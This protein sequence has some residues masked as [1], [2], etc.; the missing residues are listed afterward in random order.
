[1]TVASR[2]DHRIAMAFVCLGLA[3]KAPVTVDDAGPIAT[4]FPGF[5]E[6]MRGLGAEI[7]ESET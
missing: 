3:A 1:V 6:L 7:G 4:S 2:L 5:V